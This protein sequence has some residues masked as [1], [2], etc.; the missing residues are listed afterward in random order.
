MDCP[1]SAQII[2][3]LDQAAALNRQD[4][5][6]E[7]HLI[8]LPAYGQAIMTGDFHGCLENF[9][10]LQWFADLKRCFHRHV[11]I[12]ELIH[13]N[14][15]HPL[16]G[17]SR[18]VEDCSCMLLIQAAMWKIEFPDQVHFLLG[19]HDLAQIT[20]REITKGGSAS[21]ANFNKWIM[22]RFGVEDGARIIEKITEFL[23]TLPLA[24]KCPNHIWLSHSL[25][26]PLDMDDFD[27][28]IFDRDWRLE[29]MTPRGSVYDLVWGRSHPPDQLKELAEMLRVDFFIL[30]HQRQEEGYAALSDR[31]IILASDHS[32]GCFLP[33]DLATRYT[34]KDLVARIKFFIHLPDL[35]AAK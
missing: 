16:D 1:Q 26:G 7:G 31:L 15:N 9:Q 2:E 24:A 5:F 34:F 14:G 19:N 11:I 25:P 29:D 18:A 22:A 17:H 6:R 10:K 30:G 12:H 35:P 3:I 28:S 32:Q 20:T 13:S 8:K 21:I 33:I 4:P 27:F 23:L